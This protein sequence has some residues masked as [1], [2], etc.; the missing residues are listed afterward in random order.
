[1]K[2]HHLAML[3]GICFGIWPLILNR[4]GAKPFS[5]MIVISIVI[6]IFAAVPASRELAQDGLKGTLIGVVVL[7]AIFDG[8]GLLSINVMLLE[9]SPEQIGRLLLIMVMTQITLPA[10]ATLY[11]TGW[12]IQKVTGIICAFAAVYLLKT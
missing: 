6:M 3:A 11:F 1:M 5:A 8:I 12:S 2:P 10:I 9:A 7:A 4:S